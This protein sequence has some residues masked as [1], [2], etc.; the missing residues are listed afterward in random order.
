M[1]DGHDQQTDI[2]T[3]ICSNSTML[4]LH[5]ACNAVEKHPPEQEF[6]RKFAQEYAPQNCQ[7][8]MQFDKVTAKVKGR[9]FCQKAQLMMQCLSCYTAKALFIRIGRSLH[10]E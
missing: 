4:H 5:K 1:A 6:R 8:S 3:P 7:N 2:T 9:N 10:T